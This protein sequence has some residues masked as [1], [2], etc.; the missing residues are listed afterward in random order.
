MDKKRGLRSY[1]DWFFFL[2]K[3]PIV[4]YAILKSEK[5]IALLLMKGHGQNICWKRFSFYSCCIIWSLSFS[6]YIWFYFLFSHFSVLV[7][8]LIFFVLVLFVFLQEIAPCMSAGL[9]IR[10][11]SVLKQTF[12]HLEHHSVRSRGLNCAKTSVFCT[13]F[14]KQRL[15]FRLHSDNCQ[16]FI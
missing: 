3:C 14:I 13:I 1:V 15:W 7:L 10:S 16:N 5:K 6:V 4:F 8:N 9:L 11:R 12:G 2:R